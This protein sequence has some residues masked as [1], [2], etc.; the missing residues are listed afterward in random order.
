MA[1]KLDLQ[2][3]IIKNLFEAIKGNENIKKEITENL[4]S[5]L[6]KENPENKIQSEIFK[7]KYAKIMQDYTEKVYDALLSNINNFQSLQ[8]DL[9]KINLDQELDFNKFDD[10]GD[11]DINNFEEGLRE[12]HEEFDCFGNN[13]GIS[14]RS[15][16][17]LDNKEEMI[18]KLIIETRNSLYNK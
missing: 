7:S 2:N 18:S 1:S 8:D 16:F 4:K 6:I 12:H 10:F 13:E 9:Q 15:S 14:Y 5:R 11:N 17:N 3:E